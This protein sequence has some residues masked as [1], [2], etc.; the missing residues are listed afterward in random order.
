MTVR[1]PTVR[2]M[3]VNAVVSDGL[4]RSHQVQL[5]RL[6]LGDTDDVL[7]AFTSNRDMGRQG[8]VSSRIEAE[9]YVSALLDPD[10]V[11]R[12]WA[13]TR[14]DRLIGLVC[15][16]LDETNRTG[17]FW[18]WMADSERGRGWASRAAATVADWALDE[19][20]LERLELG[21]RVNNPAS[22]AVAQTAGFIREG[23]ER[24][25]FLV[26]GV[27][28]DVHT[29]GRLRSDPRPQYVSIDMENRDTEDRGRES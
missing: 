12:P 3:G 9:R 29:Y 8:D 20:G 18:Y 5:R 10:G 22:G 2:G 14:A 21:H 13:V 7:A 23:T 11:H 15:V 19:L 25:K 6:R 28:I 4:G 26:D 16:D 27:R 24:G 1:G 17:W